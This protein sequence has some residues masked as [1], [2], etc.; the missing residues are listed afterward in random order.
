MHPK[1]HSAGRR[2]SRPPTPQGLRRGA[3]R[4]R[5]LGSED[6]SCTR[7]E[8]A[9][10]LRVTTLGGLCG[11]QLSH[12]AVT[13]PT[14]Q[15]AKACPR[16]KGEAEETPRKGAK[17]T[18]QQRTPRPE[19]RPVHPSSEGSP[20]QQPLC[21]PG[22]CSEAGPSCGSP[23]ACPPEDHDGFPSAPAAGL[24]YELRG[25]SQ[26]PGLTHRPFSPPAPLTAVETPGCHCPTAPLSHTGL[27]HSHTAE[28]SIHTPVCLGLDSFQQPLQHMFLTSSRTRQ[29]ES[30]HLERYLTVSSLC[31]SMS[32]Q[33][34]HM[35]QMGYPHT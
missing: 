5:R 27:Y 15:A 18:R 31:S 19:A 21:G 33:P 26:E 14:L 28:S 22:P 34:Q 12:H 35:C 7:C 32:P 11:D 17:W 1:P 8:S 25:V 3:S 29:P 13:P 6:G 23:T 10:C 20:A 4:G 9:R 16:R 24:V 30:H 2:E